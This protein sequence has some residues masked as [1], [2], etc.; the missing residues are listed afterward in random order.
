MKKKEKSQ[1]YFLDFFFF[2]KRAPSSQNLIKIF[3][4]VRLEKGH[5]TS[6]PEVTGSLEHGYTE[7]TGS[8]LY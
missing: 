5:L 2:P 6:S 8:V 7:L 4:C 3:S 1:K